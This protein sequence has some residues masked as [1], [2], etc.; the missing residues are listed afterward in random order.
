MC[1]L[2]LDRSART[3]YFPLEVSIYD[4]VDDLRRKIEAERGIPFAD[5]K[6]TCR[7]RGWPCHEDM[8]M[9]GSSW[10]VPGDPL[11]RGSIADY[12]IDWEE[13]L[14]V[15][16]EVTVPPLPT[17]TRCRAC[18][19]GACDLESGPGARHEI[20]EWA[21]RAPRPKVDRNRPCPCGSGKKFKKC[22]G[23]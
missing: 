4:T 13:Q 1:V 8:K 6:I 19:D 17:C 23:K 3:L 14:R 15:E 2:W 16:T 10:R 5:Q 7:L 18:A 12:E 11:A 9:G 21:T 22:C 20:P